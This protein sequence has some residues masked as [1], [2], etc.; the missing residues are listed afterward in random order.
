M[1]AA[2]ETQDF[3]LHSS[4]RS[5]GAIPKALAGDPFVH[6]YAMSVQEHRWRAVLGVDEN[7]FEN[8]LYTLPAPQDVANP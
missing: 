7:N 2:G 3:S 5:D 4:L 8:T 1:P 6:D